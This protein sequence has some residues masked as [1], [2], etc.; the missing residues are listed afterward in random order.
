MRKHLVLT[1]S[2]T[3]RPGIVGRLT[4]IVMSYSGNVEASRMAHLGGEFAVLMLVSAPEEQLGALRE[5]V[6]Q[7][8]DEDFKVTTRPTQIGDS[9]RY[10]G[11]RPYQIGVTGADHEGIIHRIANYLAERQVNI[12]SMDTG[13]GRAPMSGAPLFAMQA[14][15][16][17]PPSMPED[18]LREAL[19]HIGAEAGVEISLARHTE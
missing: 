13:L 9:T 11:Y 19:A 16:L 18:E 1:V 10:A 15:M 8:R 2:G 4:Q 3:D 17:V 6:R 14:V 12:E 7:L 5:G